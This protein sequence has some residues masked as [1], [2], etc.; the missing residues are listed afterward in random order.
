MVTVNRKTRIIDRTW[1]VQDSW[2]RSGNTVCK[3]DS[4]DRTNRRLVIVGGHNP[5]SYQ[6][7]EEIA[8]LIATAPDMLKTLEK[9]A[10]FLR[11]NEAEFREDH[12]WRWLF[13]DVENVIKEATDTD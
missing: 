13:E 9:V 8:A 3:I 11:D 2:S 12:E 7:V 4:D 10:E 6:D 1:Q 5:I